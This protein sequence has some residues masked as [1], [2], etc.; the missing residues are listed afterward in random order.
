MKYYIFADIAIE[1]KIYLIKFVIV[2]RFRV[3]FENKYHIHE[4]N[5]GEIMAELH[6]IYQ[7]RVN[8][9]DLKSGEEWLPVSQSILL[10]HHQL[11]QDAV[12]YY[13]LALASMASDPDSAVGKMKKRMEETWDDF[14]R[15]GQFR[16]GMKRSLSRT[17][18][19]P[20]D[21]L[22][23]VNACGRILEGNKTSQDIMQAAVN[24][25]VDEAE[26]D[27]QGSG[28][29]YFARL[30]ETKHKGN[31]KN[32]PL[33]IRRQIHQI[34][35]PEFILNP[36][37]TWD[38]PGFDEFDIY[39]IV[40]PQEGSYTP[41]ESKNLLSRCIQT[42]FP[43][44]SEIKNNLE[45]LNAKACIEI[46]KYVASSAKGNIKNQLFAFI[47]FYYLHKSPETFEMLRKTFPKIPKSKNIPNV[48]PNQ[49][50]P[51]RTSRGSRGYVFPA[52]TQIINLAWS[53]TNFDIEAFK[54]AL[55]TLNQF[56]QKTKERDDEAKKVLS[57]L[58]WMNGKTS[59][60][61]EIEGEEEY[62]GI[63]H[64]DP[65]WE[66]LLNIL[67]KDLSVANELTEGESN[68]Y[69]LRPRT[70]RGF[71]RLRQDCQKILDKSDTLSDDAIQIK[72]KERL[73]KHQ[74]EH[75][76]DM[77]S[78]NLF[79]KLLEKD[80]W[81]I[82]RT[83]DEKMA[84]DV[85]KNK[86]SQ[87]LLQDAV[88]YFEKQQDLKDLQE[89]INFTPAD[90][91]LSRRICNISELGSWLGRE[92]GHDPAG[93]F[94]CRVPLAVK[95]TSTGC[96][97]Q[98]TVRIHY[99][100]PRLLRD[101]LRK[102][103]KDENLTQT[104]FLPPMAHCLVNSPDPQNFHTCAVQLMPD[105]D[106]EG[107]CRILL[108]FPISVNVD[109]IRKAG[110]EHSR[111][112]HQ[113][114]YSNDKNVM[115]LWPQMDDKGKASWFND[116]SSF[117]V[118]SVDL[119]QRTA[120]AATLI[121]VTSSKPEVKYYRLLGNTGTET[122]YA[123]RIGA[124]LIRLPGED[125]KIW[126]NGQNKDVELSG[127]FGRLPSQDEIEEA[128][129]ICISLGEDPE[130]LLKGHLSFPETNDKLIVA[131]RR[132]QRRLSRLNR[133]L[134]MLSEE[135]KR[136]VAIQE[137]SKEESLKSVPIPQYE[138]ILRN[139]ESKLRCELPDLFL[140]LTN[141]ILPLRGRHWQF[142]SHPETGIRQKQTSYLLS[143]TEK[144]S[145]KFG[146]KICGQ[147]GLSFARL[148]QL[149]E[150]RKRWQ[151]LNRALMRSP[152]SR[153][154]SARQMRENQIPDPCPDILRKLDAMR[155][156]RV[157]QTANQIVAMAL[158]V[159]LKKHISNAKER[160]RIDIHGEYEPIPGR[161]P[162]AFIVMEDLSRYLT[163]Q[164][165]SPSE[166]SRLMKWAHRAILDKV[167]M[168]CEPFGI[169]VLQVPAAFSSRFCSASGI[170]GFRAVELTKA[171][172]NKYPWNKLLAEAQEKDASNDA[173]KCALLFSMFTNDKQT[174]LAPKAGGPIFIPAKGSDLTTQA[175]I[176]A[177]FNIGLRALAAPDQFHVHQ[178]VRSHK[179]SGQWAAQGD[180]KFEKARFGKGK[181]I[182]YAPSGDSIKEA[183]SKN[184]MNFFV[185]IAH[186]AEYD[187]AK[188][189]DKLLPQFISTNKGLW[190]KVRDIQWERCLQMNEIRIK[191]RRSDDCIPM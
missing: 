77:G 165:R 158:G 67:K 154:E 83:P 86:W 71:D 35:L 134:W 143:Q 23:M 148:E 160:G 107:K 116:K 20:A 140:A 117:H 44:N 70:V 110:P 19:V 157:N 59:K 184:I 125:M 191:S 114:V 24:Q 174:L 11:F 18:G 164:G 172:V 50:D 102:N 175:D 17:L 57:V 79:Q 131:A 62:I 161:K 13:L 92:Y 180:S 9:A 97:M 144:G 118:L 12:N 98:H 3:K 137:I 126:R 115:L 127:S 181:V 47:I 156:Q 179:K 105:W 112:D 187:T 27:I 169:P 170:A 42:T 32:D 104:A 69:G 40:T 63:L 68:D 55:K 94:T 56:G 106:K 186:V 78:A 153:P 151:S 7:G 121:E 103:S 90:V 88:I 135:T 38:S 16:S 30:C 52:F 53:N 142:T 75:R 111:W 96:W 39:S 6:R 163:S 36:N 149:E 139:H 82:W 64:G 80:N 162:V 66:K 188:F 43:D 176:N 33:M 168:L 91:Q 122:W 93:S 177:A 26:G 136:S 84:E 159:R 21:D 87:D 101:G 1:Y 85:L 129:N 120:G 147:R 60:L 183:A 73:D 74:A 61:P 54:E 65:R 108:N 25:I 51:V 45:S 166:N 155:E 2:S 58:N 150:L 185:D 4:G 99:S 190:G 124:E 46:P 72:L 34:K 189:E 28:R 31:F 37:T 128:K 145:D 100:A 41:K 29:T 10:E 123:R 130:I 178:R 132:A 138:T 5:Q 141:R 119:G 167:K 152:G 22:S 146:K 109:A 14:A 113:F 171:D 81:D 76:D 173:R 15:K 133:W 95:D 48:I 8:K 49:D 182:N 89:P